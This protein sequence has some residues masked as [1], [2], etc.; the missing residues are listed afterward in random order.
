LF[1]VTNFFKTAVFVLG[2]IST[3]AAQTNSPLNVSAT[4]KDPSCFESSD[5]NI[6]L[7]VIGGV[8]P[9]SYAWSNSE[10]A[11]LLE[12]LNAGM[13]DVTVQDALNNA[14]SLSIELVNPDELTITGLVTPVSIHGGSDGAI[15]VTVS[16]LAGGFNMIWTSV[17][18]AGYDLYQFDQTNLTPGT[19]NLDIT[20][21]F[22]CNASASFQV[23]Q[24][25]P[26]LITF[27]GSL[28]NTFTEN[29]KDTTTQIMI[30]PNPS[31]G[32][33]AFKNTDDVKS[34]NVYNS[35]GTLVGTLNEYEVG[36]SSNGLSFEHGI[37][38]V[39]FE[40]KDGTL[41]RQGL[42]IR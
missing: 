38:N 15:D 9:Y 27:N 32:N 25:Y 16:G 34:V 21:E 8:P 37:Y 28:A 14:V 13:Y 35:F 29:E 3:V 18:G 26:V 12:N 41:V 42:V 24:D 4:K 36:R 20:T 30:Y 5:G 2:S 39:V 33:F 7:D 1:H 23:G 19:Y 40:R 11:A 22:G 17:D 31:E 6:F 10:S